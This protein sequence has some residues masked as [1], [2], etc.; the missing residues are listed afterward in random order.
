MFEWQGED[1]L[2]SIWVEGDWTVV[3]QAL[4]QDNPP[5]SIC[6]L[7][8]FMEVKKMMDYPLAWRATQI[9]GE[10]NRAKDWPVDWR[11]RR[12]DP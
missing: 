6:F 1:S 2:M 4:L 3:I 11:Q 5:S 8:I 7:P 10:G 12:G 9:Y